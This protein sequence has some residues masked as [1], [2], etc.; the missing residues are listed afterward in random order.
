M[1]LHFTNVTVAFSELE[2]LAN[3]FKLQ[4]MRKLIYIWLSVFFFLFPICQEAQK[5]V[6]NIET[7]KQLN[8][9]YCIFLEGLKCRIY[10][11]LAKS[12]A[13]ADQLT[14]EN[15]LIINLTAIDLNFHLFL[16]ESSFALFNVLCKMTGQKCLFVKIFLFIY[17]LSHTALGF[18]V[19]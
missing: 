8:Y 9:Y 13:F 1:F 4:I 16:I 3:C 5:W 18:S 7:T 11:L 6:C 2:R 17:R 14:K 12:R 19:L 10:S 15:L